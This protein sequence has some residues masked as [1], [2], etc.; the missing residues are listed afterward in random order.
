MS[1]SAEIGRWPADFSRRCIQSGEAPFVT[2]RTARPKK[3][4]QPSAVLDA[5]RHRAGKLPSICGT[6][7][8]LER[9]HARR[10][11]VARDA[12]HAHAILAVGSDRHVEHRVV[13]PGILR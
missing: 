11:E 6:A 2:P 4:G 12:A 7:E 13:E 5:D 10:G 9:A 1:T 8:R 3:A